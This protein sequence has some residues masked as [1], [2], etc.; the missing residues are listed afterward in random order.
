MDKENKLKVNNSFVNTIMSKN[1]II[2][3]LI[4]FILMFIF[5]RIGIDIIVSSADTKKDNVEDVNNSKHIVLKNNSAVTKKADDMSIQIECG[6]NNKAKMYSFVEIK[7]TIDNQ[8]D[9]F[10][11]VLQ[12]G[13]PQNKEGTLYTK[14]FDIAANSKDTI[15]MYIPINIMS[16]KIHCEILNRS[17][18]TVTKC[19]IDLKVY[20]QNTFMVGVLADKPKQVNYIALEKNSTYFYFDKDTIPI[21]YRALDAIDILIINRFDIKLLSRNQYI[22]ITDWISN[23]GTLVLGIGEGAGAYL[24]YFA[25]SY[26]MVASG[27]DEIE[28][29]FVD[30][31]KNEIF[32]ILREKIV[33]DNYEIDE[34]IWDNFVNAC[35]SGTYT[36][37]SDGIE[38]GLVSE[39][40]K[41]NMAVISAYYEVVRRYWLKTDVAKI[42]IEN[43]VT[44]ESSSS[45]PILQSLVDGKGKIIVAS[46]DLALNDN[47]SALKEQIS[48]TICSYASVENKTIYNKFLESILGSSKGKV[49]NTLVYIVILITYI[50]AIIVTYII[51]NTKK[52]TKK[53]L[54]VL[55]IYTAFVC[56]LFM[57]LGIGTRISKLHSAHIIVKE[58]KENGRAKVEEYFNVTVPVNKIYKLK[59]KEK[60]EVY[61]ISTSTDNNALVSTDN[62]KF[63]T[64]L[65]SKEQGID[66]RFDGISTFGT[67]TFLSNY[68]EE[69]DEK[70]DVSLNCWDNSYSGVIQNKT[71]EDFDYVFIITKTAVLYFGDLDKNEK[72]SEK[73]IK[74]KNY[75][76]LDEL[77]TIIPL[78][79]DKSADN[80]SSLDSKGKVT[81]NGITRA[82]Q[83]YMISGG[84]SGMS[85]GCVFAI[86]KNRKSIFDEKNIYEEGIDIVTYLFDVNYSVSSQRYIPNI[87]ISDITFE[88]GNYNYSSTTGSVFVVKN[89]IADFAIEKEVNIV[90]MKFLSGSNESKENN[91]NFKGKVC[92]WNYTTKKYDEIFS[93][94]EDK[95]ITDLKNYTGSNKIIKIKFD[96][97]SD[98]TGCNLPMISA[99][100]TK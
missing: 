24:G 27:F 78:L 93:S 51:M 82:M 77:E 37:T 39:Q 16:H 75:T 74:H 43:G 13:I 98:E 76:S 25:T 60:N 22:A 67:K 72:V 34:T 56:M 80:R 65:T 28:I 50:V 53:L 94:S 19:N 85:Q 40:K 58:L 6:L 32:D 97:D 8:G 100:V 48:S 1:N 68:E 30:R 33:E 5:F 44:I 52:K 87:C 84:I 7:V 79:M 62:D 61:A 45:I 26:N 81:P 99:I 57:F 55:P 89:T 18:K 20:D 59:L 14:D 63:S 15:E 36:N 11:G 86:K 92:F 35:K 83:Y 2:R 17:G 4:V 9:Y 12:V 23:G 73:N 49:P 31:N 66:I 38:V 54:I 96:V 88:F 90:S 47:Y 41:A 71:K 46:F 29:S 3:Y 91:R 42:S 21:D 10:A 64:Y 69:N 70:F 95:T